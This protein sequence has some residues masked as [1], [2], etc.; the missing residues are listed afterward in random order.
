[1]TS[2]KNVAIVASATMLIVAVASYFVYEK[3]YSD[4]EK[5]IELR[6]NETRSEAQNEVIKEYE[7]KIK[8]LTDAH[9]RERGQYAQRMLELE[10][11][12]RSA[13]S[14]ETCQRERSELAR[15][16]IR[17]ERLLIRAQSYLEATR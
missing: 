12:E 11:F 17:G 3:G 5:D 7:D 4:A 15:L 14:L 1:M 2:L 13:G 9:N 6:I 16:A 8:N 10:Q